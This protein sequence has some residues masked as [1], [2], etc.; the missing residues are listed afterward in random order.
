MCKTPNEK[1]NH[2]QRFGGFTKPKLQR[3]DGYDNYLSSSSYID[4]KS[5]SEE[6]EE[7][8]ESEIKN[9]NRDIG[10]LKFRRYK[11]YD[12]LNTIRKRRAVK[13]S[14]Q[15]TKKKT[16][17]QLKQFLPDL[18]EVSKSIAKMDNK[19]DNIIRDILNKIEKDDNN[20]DSDGSDDNLFNL[21]A[22]QILEELTRNNNNLNDVD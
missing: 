19:K 10:M 8:I 22:S 16:K 20:S 12:R 15:A 9:L 7:I 18:C 13:Q 14:V 5:D 4:I 2:F 21:S 6:E 3:T 17:E 11:K 1:R